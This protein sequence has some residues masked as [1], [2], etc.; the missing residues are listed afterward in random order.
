MDL[1]DKTNKEKEQEFDD[2]IK[3]IGESN[4][5]EPIEY[6]GYIELPFLEK[7]TQTDLNDE[8]FVID[9]NEI[10]TDAYKHIVAAYGFKSFYD[11][12]LYA[13]ADE[14]YDNEAVL[15][16]NKDYD[17]LNRV[18]RKVTRNGKEVEMTFYEKPRAGS[19]NKEKAKANTDD[20]EEN[21][22]NTFQIIAVGNFE[23]PIPTEELQALNNLSA[24]FRILK[25]KQAD[26]DRLKLLVDSNYIPRAVIGLKIVNQYLTIK[27][28]SKDI[29]VSGLE[30]RAFYELVKVALN[31]NKGVR[32]AKEEGFEDIEELAHASELN[33]TDLNYEAD[34]QELY[35]LF[36]EFI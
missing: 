3:R 10:Y 4:A 17:S 6:V 5:Q 14:V 8:Q 18:K 19:D 23:D 26:C 34:P 16:S 7:I 21:Q 33:E 11:L 36:G 25:G 13:K 35:E 22:A 32:V 31:I 27:H 9:N 29:D 24:G 30:I 1:I 28:L 2:V 15:K 12:Y 20:S